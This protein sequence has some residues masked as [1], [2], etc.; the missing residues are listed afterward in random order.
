MTETG[1]AYQGGQPTP[2]EP[3]SPHMER[4]MRQWPRERIA[5]KT[6]A[7]GLDALLAEIDRLRA[8]NARLAGW[9]APR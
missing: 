8:E 1:P 3:L 6:V 2:A 4:L 9:D 5:P 7:R